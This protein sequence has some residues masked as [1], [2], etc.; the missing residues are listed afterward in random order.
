MAIIQVSY[1]SG[2]GHEVRMKLRGEFN[3]ANRTQQNSQ[4]QVQA[5]L[6][7]PPLTQYLNKQKKSLS[8][9]FNPTLILLASDYQHLL[10]KPTSGNS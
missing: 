2:K 6:F 3:E 1:L 5:K 9:M 7:A 4:V 10:V 8:K